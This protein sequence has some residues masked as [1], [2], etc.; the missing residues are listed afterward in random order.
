GLALLG[1][2]T[3]GSLTGS[4]MPIALK[5]IGADPAASS[6]PFV[7]TVVDVTGILIFFGL[8]LAILRGTLL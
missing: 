5:R 6:T 1:V 8:A 4:L 2:V 7:A 3:W